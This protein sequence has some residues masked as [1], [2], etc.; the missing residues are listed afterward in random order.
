VHY[1]AYDRSSSFLW[2]SAELMRFDDPGFMSETLG[3]RISGVGL[4]GEQLYAHAQSQA[5]LLAA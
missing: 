2:D 3:E 4:S 5:A 1:D